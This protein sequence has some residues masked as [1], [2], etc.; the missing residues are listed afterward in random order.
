MNRISMNVY[1]LTQGTINQFFL[2]F[3]TN[4]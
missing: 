1:T 2:L 3:S 4:L